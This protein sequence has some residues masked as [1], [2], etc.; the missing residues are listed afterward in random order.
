MLRRSSADLCPSCGGCLPYDGPP[1]KVCHC[2]THWG[3][4]LLELIRLLDELLSDPPPPDP[5]PALP[6][7][8][9]RG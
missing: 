7:T 5:V 9:E 8:E 2:G 1:R 4:P 6:D 3:D